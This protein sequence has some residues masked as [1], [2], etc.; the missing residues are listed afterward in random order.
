MTAKGAAGVSPWPAHHEVADVV[1]SN[2]KA[3]GPPNFDVFLPRPTSGLDV[4]LYTSV[5][6]AAGAF[7]SSP[8]PACAWRAFQLSTGK[9]ARYFAVVRLWSRIT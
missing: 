4:F 6:Y 7:S 8:T 5:S 2:R 3:W 9:D 1:G